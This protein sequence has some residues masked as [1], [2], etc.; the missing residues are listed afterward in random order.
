ML[1]GVGLGPGSP[2]LMT[3]RA[4]KILRM[5]DE[6]IVP[7]DISYSIVSRFRKPKLIRFPM[8]K[9]EDVVK[10]LSEELSR[11]C[12]KED[13]AFA[14][15]G[16]PAFYSTFQLVAEKVLEINP[17]TK[18]EMIPGIPSF[19]S[20]FSRMNIFVRD[21][22]LVTV[23]GENEIKYAVM[24]KSTKPE[25]ACEEMRLMGMDELYLAERVF[26]NDEKIT[27]LGEKIPEKADYFSIVIGVKK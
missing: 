5:A 18:I 27:R 25:I 16:D 3:V 19:T 9:S 13:I 6:V 12:V 17:E 2:D 11:R 8:G 21:P 1:F 22:M 14:C 20:V 26:M 23:P 15:L 10:K 7:G 24:L 4:I